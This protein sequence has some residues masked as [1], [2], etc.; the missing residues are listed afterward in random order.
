[1]TRLLACIAGFAMCFIV[2]ESALAHTVEGRN[3][4]KKMGIL[5]REELRDALKLTEEQKERIKDIHG[6]TRAVNAKE[7]E[8][9]RELR[10]NLRKLEEAEQFDRAGVETMLRRMAEIKVTIKANRLEAKAKVRS[11]LSP[12][13]QL[14]LSE[15]REKAQK[16]REQRKQRRHD[17]NRDERE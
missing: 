16:K 9:L 5:H 11:E 17:R 14:I 13:Q 15:F 8:K 7:R 3:G 12:E 2:V 10:N 4:A 6:A 1:M